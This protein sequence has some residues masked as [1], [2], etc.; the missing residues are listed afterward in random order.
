V[1][2]IKHLLVA[3][4][5]WITIKITI[6]GFN[7]K[8]NKVELVRLGSK[9]GGWWLPSAAISESHLNRVAISAGLGFDVSFDKSLLELGFTVIGLD[10]LADCVA[11][12]NSNLDEFPNFAALEKGLWKTTGVQSFYPP[13]N[14]NHDSWSATNIQLSSESMPKKFEVISLTDLFIRYP[15]L[16]T[17]DYRIIKMDIEG[18]E[19]EVMKSLTTFQHRF[20]F[21]AI[22][23]DFLSLIPFMKFRHRIMMI[24]E[25]RSLLGNFRSAGY[26]LVKTENFN[27]FW[28]PTENNFCIP[29]NP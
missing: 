23:I 14:S 2:R 25:A 1:L 7:S 11:H 21:I 13:K 27:F 16:Q 15:Q 29:K 10:P 4:Q 20:D 6:F 24:K 22:E 5:N 18:S 19:L 17:C 26:Q 8:P 9:Y 3:I 12:A 28:I